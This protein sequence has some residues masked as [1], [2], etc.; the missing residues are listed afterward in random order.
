[1]LS[2][3]ITSTHALAKQDACI[4]PTSASLYSAFPAISLLYQ[5]VST[6]SFV[7]TNLCHDGYIKPDGF[8]R[9]V[10]RVPPSDGAST[11]VTAG[12]IPG[13]GRVSTT[14]TALLPVNRLVVKHTRA[15]IDR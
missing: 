13:F 4:R 11:G 12:K 9:K 7:A 5:A 8:P 2:P 10:F 1:V 6:L 14:M 15:K 3:V